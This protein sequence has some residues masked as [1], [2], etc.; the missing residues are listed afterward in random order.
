MKEKKHIDYSNFDCLFSCRLMVNKNFAN[1][2]VTRSRTVD[3]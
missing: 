3:K 1:K 2:D